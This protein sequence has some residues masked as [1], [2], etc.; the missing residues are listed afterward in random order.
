MV[1][2]TAPAAGA[3]QLRTKF[4]GG[5]SATTDVHILQS[6][7]PLFDGLING[8]GSTQTFTATINV[9]A[10]EVVDFV[11]GANGN[12]YFDTTFLDV[13]IVPGSP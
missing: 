12:Y 7:Q 10:G 9:A 5:D 3:Y 11:V 1:R 2:W 6:G 8:Q 4:S 13:R